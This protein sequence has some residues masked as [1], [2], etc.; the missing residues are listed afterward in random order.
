MGILIRKA[1]YVKGDR[2][3][4]DQ[5]DEGMGQTN[6]KS[7]TYV[8]ISPKSDRIGKKNRYNSQQRLEKAKR[9]EAML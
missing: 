3:A 5:L 6:A 8:S 7:R 1:G 9:K 2:C 4:E